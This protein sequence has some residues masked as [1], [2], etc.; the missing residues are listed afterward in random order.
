M[1]DDKKAAAE[2]VINFC[3][4]IVEAVDAG[5]ADHKM[6]VVDLYQAARNHVKSEYDFDADP[7]VNIVGKEF[8][9]EYSE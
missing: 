4:M 1:T 2:A 8:I 6:T 5:F 7:L 9:D 3:R